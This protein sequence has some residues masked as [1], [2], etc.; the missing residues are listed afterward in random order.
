MTDRYEDIKNIIIDAEQK[1]PVS[2]WKIG[3]VYIWPVL[4]TK[5]FMHVIN[6]DFSK[7][8]SVKVPDKIQVSNSKKKTRIFTYI[9][10]TFKYFFWI[11]KLKVKENL[12]LGSDNYRVNIEN[13][14][15]NRFFDPLIIKYKIQDNSSLI[16]YDFDSKN[17]YFKNI[18]INYNDGL[19]MFNE[20]LY[21]AYYF[22]IRKPKIE[23]KQYAEFIDYIKSFDLTVN[24]ASIY[25]QYRIINYYSLR[26]NFQ[27]KNASNILQSIKPKKIFTLCYYNS[28]D[29]MFFVAAAKRKNIRTIEMQHGPIADKHLAYGNWTNVPLTGYDIIPSLFWCWDKFSK[30]TIDKSLGV[31][32]NYSSFIGGHPWIEYWKDKEIQDSS[33]DSEFILYTI[34]QEFSLEYFFNPKIILLIKHTKQKWYIR[35][36][37]RQ[38]NQKSEIQEYLKSKNI[39]EYVDIEN[40]TFLPLP[41]LLSKALLNVTSNSGTTIEAFLF[42]K[43]TVLLDP[44]SKDYY[45]D[46]IELNLAKYLDFNADNFLDEFNNIL[47]ECQNNQS[48]NS[49]YYGSNQLF[50]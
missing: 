18:S 42:N 15:F 34:Q 32:K 8:K 49:H 10:N 41:L 11:K 46:I 17:H 38:I 14:R 47:N 25:S 9:L 1:F 33:I 43:F 50:N 24:L 6:E 48:E 21:R 7:N 23:I 20:S 40:A 3:D 16:E 28:S 26:W 35:L 12:F 13:K 22:F 2:S 29:V 19:K 31:N 30:S 44:L 36:H 5:I 39:L 37:P 45:K 27:Y 4:R